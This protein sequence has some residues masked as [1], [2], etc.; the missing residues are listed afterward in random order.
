M[1]GN[2]SFSFISFSL[3]IICIFYDKRFTVKQRELNFEKILKLLYHIQK[4]KTLFKN[5]INWILSKRFNT[6]SSTLFRKK[7]EKKNFQLADKHVEL[8]K[9]NKLSI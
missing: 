7:K 9:E 2:L 4:K 3:T 6:K 5:K 1:P 8:E